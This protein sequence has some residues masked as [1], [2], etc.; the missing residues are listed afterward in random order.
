M[1]ICEIQIAQWWGFLL[2]TRQSPV[3]VAS[4]LEYESISGTIRASPD[5]NMSSPLDKK[6][7]WRTSTLKGNN[8]S[9]NLMP[10]TCTVSN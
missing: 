4:H 6:W 7:V 2:Y 10:T 1:K 8:L 5:R 3:I 9:S